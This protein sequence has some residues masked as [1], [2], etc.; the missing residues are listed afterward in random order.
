[1]II[2]VS[3]ILKESG[4][5]MSVSEKVDLNTGEAFL[6]EVYR[7]RE[8]I[9]VEGSISNNGKSLIFRAECEG[10]LE[11]SCARC[12]KDIEAK[13]TFPVD[14]NLVRAEDSENADED[15]ILFEGN[16]V[17]IDE[18][19]LNSFLMNV[20]SRFLCKED[21]KGLCAKC[22]ADLNEGDCGCDNESIDPRWA[23]LLDIMNEDKE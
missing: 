2:D 12:L 8:P 3:G 19:I 1:M 18:I 6:G 16:T 17:E 9:S 5:R 7:F 21:C 10:T 23:G 4:G 22:G 14:E 20:P 15:S 13:V 11:T